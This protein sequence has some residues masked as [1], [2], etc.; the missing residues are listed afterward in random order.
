[1]F[2]II[3]FLT[4]IHIKLWLFYYEIRTMIQNPLWY[5][6]LIAYNMLKF[7]VIATVNS[8]KVQFFCKGKHGVLW[9]LEPV[10]IKLDFAL[11]YNRLDGP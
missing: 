5:E 4:K 9:P 3:H 10:V 1:M 2:E 6:A 11:F 7:N 8:V